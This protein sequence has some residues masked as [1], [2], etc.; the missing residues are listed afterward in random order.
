ME[1]ALK[2]IHGSTRRVWVWKAAS[3]ALAFVAA[4]VTTGLVAS[5]IKAL[6]GDHVD[7]TGSDYMISIFFL[8]PVRS[9]PRPPPPPLSRI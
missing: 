9:P 2:V 3:R 7:Y 6:D 1:P 8:G 5:Y 4:V